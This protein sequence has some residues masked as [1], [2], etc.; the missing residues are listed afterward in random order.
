MKRSMTMALA[1]AAAS[2]MLPLGLVAAPASAEPASAAVGGH[3]RAAVGSVSDPL[4]GTDDMLRR[5]LASVAATERT[6]AELREVARREILPDVNSRY[7]GASILGHYNGEATSAQREAYFAAFRDYLPVEIGE[8][9]A[10]AAPDQTYIIEGNVRH[11]A[12]LTTI[13]VELPTPS[14]E[15]VYL[16][17]TWLK[18][19][20]TGLWRISDYSVQGFS[21]VTLKRNAWDGILHEEGVTGLT[22]WLEARSKIAQRER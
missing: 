8:R 3:V 17:V 7:M 13:Q 10:S 15:P 20:G 19:K 1:I 22:R 21:F 16:E 2:V 14:G 4:Q 6:P 11:S 9:L 5:T 12:I 18:D